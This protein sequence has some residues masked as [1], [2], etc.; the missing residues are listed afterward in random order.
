MEKARS[1]LF[2]PGH[3]PDRFAK[4]SNAGAHAIIIDLE[5]AV[6]P[7]DKGAARDHVVDWL[8]GGGLG[9]VRVNAADT[10]WFGADLTA[11]AACRPAAV[12]LPKAEPAAMT[13]LT[14]TLPGVPVIALIE[15]VSGLLALP[16]LVRHQAVRR[17]AFGNL[18]FSTDARLPG[19]GGVL[20]LARFQLALH[21]RAAEQ[22]PPIDGV[23]ISIDDPTQLDADVAR[24][25]EL[26]FGGKLCIHP[27][28]VEAVNR[29]FAPSSGELEWARRITAALETSGGAAVQLDGKMVDKP[30]I[31]RAQ[32]IIADASA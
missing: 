6:G 11:L 8:A 14:D 19:T 9:L 30:M 2:V 13:A 26:G 18:D 29:G 23:T 32:A 22:P 3:R 12:V 24:A 1:F 10:A 21:A 5:D 4:A 17:L 7:A 16:E 20:D 27:K 28:Q 25:R 15:T 31:T